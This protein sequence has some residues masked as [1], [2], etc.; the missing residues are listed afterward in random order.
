MSRRQAMIDYLLTK[1]ATVRPDSERFRHQ[2]N[3]KKLASNQFPACAIFAPAWRTDLVEFQQKKT[4][5][6]F[7][8][9]WVEEFPSGKEA[10]PSLLD[11]A[12]AIEGAIWGGNVADTDSAGYFA[13]VASGDLRA[14]NENASRHGLVM[15]VVIDTVD[16]EDGGFVLKEAN[17]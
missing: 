5:N 8:L 4:A 16:I 6:S 12:E 17:V 2:I 11:T 14:S 9:V 7:V 3:I 15:E 13:Y 1:V 10:Q